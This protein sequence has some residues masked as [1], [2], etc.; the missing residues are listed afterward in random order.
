MSAAHGGQVLLSQTTAN[1]VEQEL[2]DDVSL[3]DLGATDAA[4]VIE[5]E[6]TNGKKTS[7]FIDS[8]TSLIT[9]IEFVTGESKDAI[10][11]APIPRVE[12]YVFSD[13]RPVQG[14]VTPFKI[15]RYLDNIK[16]EEIQLESVTYNA[17]VKDDVF[18]P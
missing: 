18:K 6:D 3:R 15:E 12:A 10:S 4:R 17:A 7:Y 16:A 14:L 2:P 9:R 5:A 8:R 1:L 11:Q 13:F